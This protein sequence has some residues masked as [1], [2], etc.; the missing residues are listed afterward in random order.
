MWTKK[1]QFGDFSA[2]NR[3]FGKFL[4]TRNLTRVPGFFEIKTRNP[5]FQN[6]ARV[7]NHYFGP[8]HLLPLFNK[9]ATLC[10]IS[11]PEDW[12]G[13]EALLNVDM[14]WNWKPCS[15]SQVV[16]FLGT[17]YT[18]HINTE[19]VQ[20][21]IAWLLFLDWKIAPKEGQKMCGSSYSTTTTTSRAIRVLGQR[22]N[23]KLVAVYVGLDSDG[24]N[25]LV[26]IYHRLQSDIGQNAEGW[27]T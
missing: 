19:V 14:Y 6:P 17:T 27:E 7:C 3:Q 24:S 16:H 8:Y 15:T 26:N 12:G 5:F 18:S 2:K 20:Y 21:Q 4:K 23:K 10:R 1:G 13:A 22:S 9:G 11:Q 25:R